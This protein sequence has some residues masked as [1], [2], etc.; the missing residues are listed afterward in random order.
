MARD[1]SQM[2]GDLAQRA[3]KI[4]AAFKRAERD[5]VTRAALA[6]TT[7]HRERIIADS[8]G[9]SRLSRVGAR[10]GRT[11][12]AKVGARFN[13]V[14]GLAAEVKATGPLHI[15]ANPAK[16][17]TIMARSRGGARTT[18]RLADGG[19][20]RSVSHPG[21]GG[22]DTWRKALPDAERAAGKVIGKEMDQAFRRGAT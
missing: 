3:S 19:F 21:H 20:R 12:G 1:I 15:V 17:H 13:L 18:L 10:R 22:K 4:E 8:G 11:G 9:D 7:E 5:A 6:A 2:P 16:P 14:G